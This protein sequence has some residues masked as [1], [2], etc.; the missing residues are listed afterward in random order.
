MREIN[1]LIRKVQK[2][3]KRQFQQCET[4]QQYKKQSNKKQTNRKSRR[5]E[6]KKTNEQTGREN[7]NIKQTNK[8]GEKKSNLLTWAAVSAP[9]FITSGSSGGV[10]GSLW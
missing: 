9:G 2:H 4:N 6:N 3:N 7:I 1:I 5:L 10:L 8:Q